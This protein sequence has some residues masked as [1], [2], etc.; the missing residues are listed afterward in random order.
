MISSCSF[1][2]AL[3]IADAVIIAGFGIGIGLSPDGSLSLAIAIV[4]GMATQIIAV[5]TP[6]KKATVPELPETTQQ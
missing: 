6:G 3:V 1:L 5:L 2:R 4:A